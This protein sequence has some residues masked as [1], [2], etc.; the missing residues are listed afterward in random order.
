MSAVVLTTAGALAGAIATALGDRARLV[1]PTAQSNRAGLPGE[2]ESAFSSRRVHGA[3]RTRIDC[4]ARVLQLPARVDDWVIHPDVIP[5]PPMRFAHGVVVKRSLDRAERALSDTAMWRERL[6]GGLEMPSRWLAF[7]MHHL[8]A[9]GTGTIT[10]LVPCDQDLALSP[11]DESACREGLMSFVRSAAFDVKATGVRINA[12]QLIAGCDHA[13]VA[14]CVAMLASS[15]GAAIH[16][17][18]IT[19]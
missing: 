13:K 12:V 4:E 16:G 3:V 5:G 1:G 7:A 11:P 15:S 10:V 6:E 18:V 17:Q 2:M 14:G 19:V 8:A 9:R